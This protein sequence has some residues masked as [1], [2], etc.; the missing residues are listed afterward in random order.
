M[1]ALFPSGM[2]QKKNFSSFFFWG[3]GCTASS[4]VRNSEQGV[5]LIQQLK[6]KVA[7]EGPG[8]NSNIFYPF[9]NFIM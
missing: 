9:R 1:L 6:I 5:G 8:T 7:P 4:Y 3:G 2:G